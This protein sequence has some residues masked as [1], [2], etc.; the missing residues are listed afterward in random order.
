MTVR[1]SEETI[2]EC[3]ESKEGKVEIR[4]EEGGIVLANQD[5]IINGEV[6]EGG[7]VFKLNHSTFR[8]E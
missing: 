6:A 2:E 7:G 8:C 4:K 3:L 1:G 5:Y